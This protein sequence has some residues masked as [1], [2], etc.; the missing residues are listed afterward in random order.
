MKLELL[1]PSKES[2]LFLEVLIET[3]ISWEVNIL[4]HLQFKHFQEFFEDSFNVDAFLS[5]N[6][7][8]FTLES[9]KKDLEN[10]STTIQNSLVELI[11]RYAFGLD[12]V[13]ITQLGYFSSYFLPISLQG[14]IILHC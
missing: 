13:L 6:R 12:T 4:H 2:R 5:L 14:K 9:L 1:R 10:Y 7:K 8:S 3:H 11:N